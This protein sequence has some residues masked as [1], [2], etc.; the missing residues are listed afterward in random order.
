MACSPILLKDFNFVVGQVAKSVEGSDKSNGEGLNPVKVEHSK[1]GKE[2]NS[3]ESK[4]S[5]VESKPMKEVSFQEPKPTKVEQSKPVKEVNS[6]EEKPTKGSELQFDEDSIK[7]QESK[8]SNSDILI[9]S[10]EFRTANI[11]ELKSTEDVSLKTE[12]H[13]PKH[14]KQK[15]GKEDIS[16]DELKPEKEVHTKEDVIKSREFIPEENSMDMSK[17]ETVKG[18]ESLLAKDRDVKFVKDTDSETTKSMDE[19]KLVKVTAQMKAKV[20]ELTSKLSEVG[21]VSLYYSIN[22]ISLTTITKHI[23]Y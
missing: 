12:S 23:V 9:K 4:P 8:P 18:E 22:F 5:K 13:S 20:N 17:K 6:Q 10:G 19:H 7:K 16:H 2:V 15:P 3:Q 21:V 1:P 11:M 14:T